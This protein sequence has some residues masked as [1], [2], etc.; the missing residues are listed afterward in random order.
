MNKVHAIMALFFGAL[1]LASLWN[2]LSG[3]HVDKNATAYDGSV[4]LGK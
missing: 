3:V 2:G 1:I 4:G